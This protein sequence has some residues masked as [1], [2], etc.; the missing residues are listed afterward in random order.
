MNKRNKRR[1]YS[2]LVA[3]V[4]LACLFMF[5][6]EIMFAFQRMQLSRLGCASGE[7]VA[8]SALPNQ[9]T[10]CEK[11][12]AHRINS[13]ER[14]QYMKDFFSGLE[15]DVVFDS[16]I[17]NFRIYHPP[18]PPSGLLL[19]E[20]F[21]Q[22]S[23]GTK[24]LWIDVKGI[25]KT[26]WQQAVDY[27]ETCDRLYNIK[28]YVIIEAAI[29]DFINLLAARGF[30]TSYYV[31]GKYLQ[32]KTPKRITDSLAQRLLPAVKFVSQEDRLL[33]ELRS[34]FHGK[35]II[36]WALSFSNYTNLSHLRSLINDT[37]ISVVLINCKSR[38]YL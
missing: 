6:L 20:Y 30:I 19:D 7:R 16:A 37:S 13:P 25:K 36:T 3:L 17:N 33:P 2:A 18:A 9:L 12:W 5:R 22:L 21:K 24:G 11:L 15:T 4:V 34:R 23:T 14:F 28:K 35:K 10:A 27:F 1:L 29:P 32:V 8:I 38:H 31:P 26:A